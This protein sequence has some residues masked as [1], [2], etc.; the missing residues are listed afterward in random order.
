[1]SAN[2]AR[3]NSRPGRR[4]FARFA[5]L[6]GKL[7]RCEGQALLEFALL[8]PLAMLLVLG[9]IVFG[10]ALNDYLVLNNATA[11]GAQQLAISRKEAT[12]PCAAVYTAVTN[13]APN[14]AAANLT[15]TVAVGGTN[16][17]SGVKGSTNV[18]CS[19]TTDLTAYDNNEQGQSVSV[20]VTYPFTASFIGFGSHSYTMSATV[21]GVLQ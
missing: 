18:T 14:L 4:L 2:R 1:M 15:F 3:G 19:G 5:A 11:L 10:V 20:T 21:G 12:D 7:A 6:R 8:S 9:G 17:V 16:Y 13:A